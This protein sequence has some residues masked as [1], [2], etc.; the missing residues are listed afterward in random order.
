[1]VSVFADQVGPDEAGLTP[2]RI[3]SVH[4]ARLEAIDGTGPVWLELPGNS[5]SADFAVGDWVL[6]DP[7]IDMLVTRLDR[8]RVFQ[9]RPEHSRGQRQ[10]VAAN[11]DTLLIVT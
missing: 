7:L 6:A 9:R 3:A 11:V 2:R 4:R 8:K 10:L 5:N 1:M